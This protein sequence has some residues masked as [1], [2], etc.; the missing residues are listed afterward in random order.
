[1]KTTKLAQTV[2]LSDGNKIPI[3]GLGTFLTTNKDQMTELIRTALDVGYRHFDTAKVYENEAY[4]GE[5]FQ[6]IFSEGIYKREDIFLVSKIMSNKNELVSDVISQTLK[7]LQ[8]DYLD[9]LYLHW[10][11]T[12]PSDQLEWNHKPVHQVWAEL[13][14]IQ[15]KGQTK[16][17]GV[18]NFNVQGLVDLLS[19]AKIKPVTLQVELHVFLQQNR[20]IEFCKRANIHVTAYSP[21]ARY[22]DV[23]NNQIL[24]DIAKKYRVPVTQILLSF[25]IQQGISVIPKTEKAFRLKENFD[26]INIVLEQNDIQEL[27][28]LD[29]NHRTIQPATFQPFQFIPIFD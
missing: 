10:S 12:P 27:K 22:T 23:I 1:M 29:I 20:L 14:E 13:E 5:A 24:N 25:L 7:D 28:K 2:L 6:K 4:I 21:L 19:Y 26:S 18:S 16:S 11:F 9:L 17:L 3:I 8:V 15:K